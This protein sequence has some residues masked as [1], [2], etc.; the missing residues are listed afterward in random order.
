M[1]D[2]AQ[3]HKI[4]LEGPCR[5]GGAA[6][7]VQRTPIWNETTFGEG[8]DCFYCHVQIPSTFSHLLPRQT[9]VE[10]KG[11][12]DVWGNEFTVTSRL[13]CQITLEKK[14]DGLVV[15][16]PDAPPVELL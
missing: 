12:H 10:L 6:T 9:E 4:D 15:F 11:L 16:V 14:H 5:G 3:R 7:D 8:P 2:A 1:L 13:A